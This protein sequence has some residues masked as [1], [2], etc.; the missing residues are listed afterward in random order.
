MIKALGYTLFE[1]T[2]SGLTHTTKTQFSNGELI[3][4]LV[5]PFTYNEKVRFISL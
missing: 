5:F 1:V 3:D 4:K 2:S